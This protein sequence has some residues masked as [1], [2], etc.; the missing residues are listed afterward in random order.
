MSAYQDALRNCS[1]ERAPWYVVPS[2]HKWFR[3]WVL[4]DTIVRTME[5]MHLKYP[6]TPPGVEGLKP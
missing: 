3:N 5:A 1:T 6:P 2:D 4:S